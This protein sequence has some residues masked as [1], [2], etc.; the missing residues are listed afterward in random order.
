MDRSRDPQRSDLHREALVLARYLLPQA[1]PRLVADHELSARVASEY[2][3]ALDRHQRPSLS[4]SLGQ[5]R[6]IAASDLWAWEG[7][8]APE[9]GRS[10]VRQHLLL[11]SAI[12]ESRPELAAYFLPSD[13]TLPRVVL[14]F[15][16][17]AVGTAA[18]AL[19]SLA[20]RLRPTRR[21]M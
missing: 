2:A 10:I 4:Q 6:P 11:I 21:P 12:L 18:A 17:V 15:T 20:L 13:V 1:H 16:A 9:P 3:R 7:A 19:R 14:R 5:G 8:A